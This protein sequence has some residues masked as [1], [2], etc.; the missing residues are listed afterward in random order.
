MS[1][2]TSA[3]DGSNKASALAIKA[4]IAFSATVAVLAATYAWRQSSSAR[5]K[6]QRAVAIIPARFAS[7]RFPGKP[8]ALIAGKPMIQARIPGSGVS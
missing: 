1:A 2:S 7:T 8:L 3:S 4:A 5:K 6:K